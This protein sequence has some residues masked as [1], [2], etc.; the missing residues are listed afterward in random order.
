MASTQADRFIHRVPGFRVSPYLLDRLKRFHPAVRI[1]W[2]VPNKC[3]QLVERC[4][5]GLL[6]HVKLLRKPVG[7]GKLRFKA[8]EPT[9]ANTVYW[10]DA[11]D[12]R[13]L[14]NDAERQK[15]LDDL[16][17]KNEATDPLVKAHAEGMIEE[18][19]DRIWRAQGK[20]I[21]FVPNPSPTDGSSADG[22]EASRASPA[23][24]C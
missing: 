2:N 5:D 4:P 12:W 11:H 14:T 23:E 19:A 15:W 22:R 17:Q 7:N 9:L 13:R 1:V 6:R 16:D 10:L 3:Y 21:P 8:E 18:G 24:G 20:R